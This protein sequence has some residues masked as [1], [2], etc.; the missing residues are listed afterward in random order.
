MGVEATPPG[1]TFP[2]VRVTRPSVASAGSEADSLG[3]G[4]D[5][6]FTRLA[7]ARSNPDILRSTLEQSDIRGEGVVGGATDIV[8]RV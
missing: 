6:D 7:K 4:L 1:A 8:V 5:E 2:S 3:S